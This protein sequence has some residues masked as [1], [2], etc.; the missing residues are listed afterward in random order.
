[1]NF[2]DAIESI[3]GGHAQADFFPGKDQFTYALSIDPDH[4]GNGNFYR[5]SGIIRP[6]SYAKFSTSA[7]SGI[8]YWLISTPKN[9]NIYAYDGDGEFISYSSLLASETV[10]GTPTSG[11]GN[12]GAYYNNYIYLATPTDLSRYGPL[13]G[14]PSLTN[15]VWTGATLGSQ[16]ALVNTTYPSASITIPNHPIHVHV[17]NKLYVGDF[18]NGQGMI[19]FVKTTK[20]SAEGD[21]NNGSTYQALTLPLGY[22][23]TDIESFGTDLAIIA[24]QTSDTL[25]IQGKAAMFLWD[26]TSSNFYRQVPIPTPLS[27]AIVNKNG[28]LFIFAGEFSHGM[29]ILRYL[30]GYS[31]EQVLFD[32][33]TTS[34]VAGAV[35]VDYSRIIWGISYISTQR[36]AS[37]MALGSRDPRI[38]RGGVFNVALTTANAAQTPVIGAVKVFQQNSGPYPRYVVGWGQT[39]NGVYGLDA[40]DAGNSGGTFV[41]RFFLHG[42]AG[43]INKIRF[44]LSAAVAST[45]SIAISILADGAE[46]ETALRTI[47]NTNDPG[48]KLVVCSPSSATFQYGYK[49]K[50]VFSNTAI[51]PAIALPITIEG[52]LFDD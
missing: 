42:R 37:V 10:I 6:V 23:P 41:S 17:D 1:M 47:N 31:F 22:M 51:D 46:T 5:P 27:S 44:P 4:H 13:D 18:K 34:P 29:Q 52:E 25:A 20:S 7:V 2:N 15:T 35:D 32:G 9:T 40:Y 12:G 19:H 33:E 8:P 24:I 14:S 36:G 26:T 16:T 11:V 48:K 30:G 28:E 39:N 43:K 3:L 21:T 45:T 49:I 38:N 50:I